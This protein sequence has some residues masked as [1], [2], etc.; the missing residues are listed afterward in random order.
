VT[1]KH[2]VLL[3][4][5]YGRVCDG[6]PAARLRSRA[7]TGRVC[8]PGPLKSIIVCVQKRRLRLAPWKRRWGSFFWGSA[9]RGARQENFT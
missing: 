6:G 8:V 2:R 5:R 7:V 3:S 4:I 1:S 9:A